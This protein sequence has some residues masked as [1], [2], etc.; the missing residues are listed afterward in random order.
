[1]FPTRRSSDLD[2]TATNA[3]DTALS[4][5][6]IFIDANSNSTFD[7]GELSTTTGTDGAW[8]FSGLGTSFNGDKVLEIK[9]GGDVETLGSAGYTRSDE[10]TSELQ[11]R[12]H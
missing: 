10:H 1:D 3:D 9:P 4:G 2:T 5:I 8:S 12:G 11:S 6:T 7:T